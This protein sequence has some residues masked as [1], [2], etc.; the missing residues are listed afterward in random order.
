LLALRSSKNTHFDRSSFPGRLL[1]IFGAALLSGFLAYSK[2]TDTFDYL[3]YDGMS[4]LTISAV[5]DD[6]VLVAIDERSLLELGRWPW[7][8][9]KHVAL[10]EKLDSSGV[11]AIAID[12]I[13][14][15]PDLDFPETD[16]LLSKV[17]KKA[18]NV[19]LPV[20]ME[21][22]ERDGRI[23]EIQPL[24]SL[25]ESAAGLGHV[26]IEIDRDGV[27]RQVFLKEGVGRTNWKHFA[28]VLHEFILG[29]PIDDVPGI[30]WNKSLSK[31]SASLNVRD[32][33]NLIPYINNPTPIQT[34][35]YADVLA[36]RIPE[37]VFKNKT[38]FVGATAA[39]MGDQITTPIGLISGVEINAHIYHALREGTLVSPISSVVYSLFCAVIIGVFL[40]LTTRLPPLYFLLSMIFLGLGISILSFLILNILRLWLAPVPVII[41]VLVA[42]PI[43]NWWRLEKVVD[44]LR[45]ELVTTQE[46]IIFNT[47]SRT[48]V[49]II[50]NMIFLKDLGTISGWVL[51]DSEGKKVYSDGPVEI[52]PSFYKFSRA[53][54][55]KNY[56][57]SKLIP[58]PEGE[59]KLAVMW[60]EHDYIGRDKIS[61]F[62]PDAPSVDENY[63]SHG[64]QI[65]NTIFQLSKTNLIV[66]ANRKIID[67]SL[68]QLSVGVILAQFDGVALLINDQARV[69]LGVDVNGPQLFDV[70]SQ[71][72]LVESQSWKGLINELAFFEQSFTV[73][74]DTLSTGRTILCRGRVIH[75]VAPLFLINITDI[76]ELKKSER[77]RVEAL[78][79]LS[80]DMRSPMTSVLALIEGART[81]KLDSDSRLLLQNIEHYI[82]RNL[83]YAENFIQL[84]KLENIQKLDIEHCD[85]HSLIYNA[86][87]EIFP[88]AKLRNIEINYPETKPEFLI[89]CD[90][91]LVERAIVNILD[92]AV[93][94]SRESTKIFID[95][96]CY[97]DTVEIKIIDEGEGIPENDLPVL[98]ESFKQGG[99]ASSGV[100]SGAGLGLR[101][102][103]AVCEKH[104][105]HVLVRNHPDMGA[106]FTLS[107]PFNRSY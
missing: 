28:L 11:R 25:A 70:L 54:S 19:I 10:I 8:R 59:Y 67:E 7:P 93:K 64:D 66:E 17:I 2:V 55:H 73:Q 23:L 37:Q 84:A 15:E 61:L 5:P 42:Y 32:Y 27:A 63:P 50:K 85:I 101:F 9:E 36:D 72:K 62:I 43:W 46:N 82:Y 80:H 24:D 89:F 87:I 1:L 30:T 44:Y 39:G 35:S 6:I 21:L 105:G 16:Q 78:N 69:L 53:W 12:I 31:N 56:L 34:I 94:Y 3:F 65:A 79:F 74:G 95:T 51:F 49:D 100:K 38:V 99:N 107:F 71:I 58:S 75:A 47:H 33:L 18:G 102:V 52:S 68:E 40:W 20:F 83:S 92:N 103:M 88:S 91:N 48:R 76:T 106:E 97:D 45:Q 41:S 77:E 4:R 26:H 96:T 22:A 104:G 29:K 90:K 86:V 14:A 60:D 81:E 57:S 13:F 98:F